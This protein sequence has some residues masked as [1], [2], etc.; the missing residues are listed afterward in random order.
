MLTNTDKENIK[1]EM[2]IGN[3]VSIIIIFCVTIFDIIQL[4]I[5]NGIELRIIIIINIFAFV[6]SYLLNFL[7]NSKYRKDLKSNSK[8][9]RIE[10]VADKLQRINYEAGSG[11]LYI[12]ILGDL[13]PKI[14]GQEMKKQET[15]FIKVNTEL[16]ETESEIYDSIEIGNKVK[17][18][19]TKFSK[20]IL[21]I[22]KN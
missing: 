15:Q 1:K 6:I 19:E 22:E 11:S 17:I 9:I 20:T 3:L 16:V 13:F 2:I 7:L 14:W 21:Q 4:L 5:N 10:I 18:Y 8:D 12:P